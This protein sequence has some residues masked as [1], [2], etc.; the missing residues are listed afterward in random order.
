LLRTLVTQSQVIKRKSTV[1][2][3]SPW[4]NNHSSRDYNLLSTAKLHIKLTFRE[5]PA[6][7][8][9]TCPIMQ[10]EMAYHECCIRVARE[11]EETAL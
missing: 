11:T 2:K 6:I 1:P 8:H 5:I 4:E 7:E 3:L 9:T 10:N